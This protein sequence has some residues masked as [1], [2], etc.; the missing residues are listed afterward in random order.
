[1]DVTA[2]DDNRDDGGGWGNRRGEGKCGEIKVR[3]VS[4][5]ALIKNA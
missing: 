2:G 1:M 5:V 4:A 3:E